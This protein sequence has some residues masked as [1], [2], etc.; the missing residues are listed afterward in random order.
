MNAQTEIPIEPSPN[1]ALYFCLT[2]LLYLSTFG[3]D[4]FVRYVSISMLLQ[5]QNF[6]FANETC[7]FC[8]LIFVVVMVDRAC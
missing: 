5:A 7:L 3:N 8:F 2:I 6:C 1:S 4:M